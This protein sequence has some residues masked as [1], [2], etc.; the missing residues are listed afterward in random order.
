MNGHADICVFDITSKVSNVVKMESN[1]K[2]RAKSYENS[3]LW[4]ECLNSP[5][6]IHAKIEA[7]RSIWAVFEDIDSN[8]NF[9]V[10]Y[11]KS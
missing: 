5:C 1:S 8:F 6:E 2:I 10:G 11:D 9:T 3:A 7:G 4:Y